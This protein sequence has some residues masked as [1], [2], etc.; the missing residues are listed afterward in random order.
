MNEVT[1]L[2][3]HLYPIHRL[4]FEESQEMDLNTNDN[5]DTVKNAKLHL[6]VQENYMTEAQKEWFLKL[7]DKGDYKGSL[8]GFCV[9]GGVFSEGIDLR[10]ESLIGVIIV[11]TGLPMICRQ[12]DILKEY[13]DGIGKDG[14]SYAYMYPGM[15]KVLQ[16][17]GRVI[18]TASDKGII[19]LL[20]NR[21][22]R[23][24]YQN[25]YPREWKQVNIVSQSQIKNILLEFWKNVVQYKNL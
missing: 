12:R 3:E 19:E 24:E 17:A 8:V 25:L 21:L 5:E 1:I 15:N 23:D 16:A 11:G 20:D 18:R 14:F 7:F 13:F 22:L 9:I 2:Y 10:E 6:V 4:Q